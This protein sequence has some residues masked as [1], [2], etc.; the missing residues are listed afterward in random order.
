MADNNVTL[1]LNSEYDAFSNL[2]QVT[3]TPPTGLTKATA[4]AFTSYEIRISDITIPTFTLGTYDTHFNTVSL[5]RFNAMITGERSLKI[6]FRIDGNY[7]LYMALKEWRGKVIN[8]ADDKVVFGMYA[9]SVNNADMYGSI[10]I[11][12]LT[13]SV[14]GTNATG[15]DGSKRVW[16]FNHV[17]CAEVTEPSFKRANSEPVSIE[18]VFFFGEISQMGI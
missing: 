11:E 8:I 15:Q 14:F 7:D 9:D 3:I 10:K 4:T 2:Y 16:E 5:K 13:T 17:I 12:G 1:L 18:A 6:P